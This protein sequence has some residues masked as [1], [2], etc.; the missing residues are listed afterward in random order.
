VVEL[1]TNLKPVELLDKLHEIEKLGGRK[2]S[3]ERYAA[4]TLDIDIIFYESII[5]TTEHLKIPHPLTHMR[6]FVLVP[7]AEIAPV[8]IHPVL[9]KTISQLLAIC[10]DEKKVLKIR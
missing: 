2:P 4:R 3:A 10:E 5:I 6:L 7:L 8:F 1:A 9:G